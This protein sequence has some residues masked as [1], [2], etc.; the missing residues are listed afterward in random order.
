MAITKTDK[1]TAK[2]KVFHPHYYQSLAL[3]SEARFVAAVAGWG[4]GKCLSLDSSVPLASGVIKKADAVVEGDEV[5]AI[6]PDLQ[7]V[8]TVVERVVDAGR[9]QAVRVT[10]E[11]GRQVLV[12]EEHPFLT[13]D[14][15]WTPI[16]NL[17]VGSRIAVTNQERDVLWDWI[18]TI[19]YLDT[20]PMVDFQVRDYHNFVANNIFLHNTMMGP[21]WLYNEICKDDGKGP[22]MV[23][24]PTYPILAR[25][26]VIELK[27]CFQGTDL[28][29]EYKENRKVYELPNGAFIHICSTDKHE[30]L[31]GGQYKAAW[32]DEAGQMSRN[33]WDEM[34]GRLAVHEGRCLMTSSPYALNF[35]YTD[36]YNRWKDGNPNYDVIQWRSIDNPY[37]KKAVWDEAKR[38]MNPITFAMKFGGEFKKKAGLVYPD[39]DK[40]TGPRP[41]LKADWPRYGGIDFGYAKAF[42]ALD[43]A[44]DDGGR[45][46]V[47]WER[48]KA[49]TTTRDHA[50]ALNPQVAYFC[51]P[52]NPQSI[53]DLSSYGLSVQAGNNAVEYGISKVTECIKDGTLIV[54]DECVNLIDESTMYSWDKKG[55]KPEKENDHLMDTLRYLVTGVCLYAGSAIYLV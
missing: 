26:T 47:Y 55:E 32:L 51:D 10:T 27:A 38:T 30:L 1:R 7:V 54:S 52:S 36:V 34:Q 8:T 23:A 37:F 31:T 48:K 18:K 19:E 9:K 6:G 41:K 2:G 44:M 50:Q 28:Q 11:S 21:P 25:T 3:R 46:I 13:I 5:F 17:S 49:Q 20:I 35:F 33:V 16:A 40:C 4:G 29:G 39:F 24:A 15:A 42:G 45:V 43:A 12:S 14:S 22:Y 53:E